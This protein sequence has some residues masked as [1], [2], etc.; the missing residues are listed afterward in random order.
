MVCQ[1][2]FKDRKRCFLL[3]DLCRQLDHSHPYL[4]TSGI[5]SVR[6]YQ[7]VGTT[8]VQQSSRQMQRMIEKLTYTSV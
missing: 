6:A 3:S 1:K 8:T 2:T 7:R 4:D 5:R